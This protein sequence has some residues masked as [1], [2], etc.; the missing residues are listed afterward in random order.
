MNA[1][2]WATWAVKWLEDLHEWTMGTPVHTPGDLETPPPPTQ[3]PPV[4]LSKVLFQ[5]GKNEEVLPVKKEE[6]K[7]SVT[8]T[9]REKRHHGIGL[10]SGGR[11]GPVRTWRGRGEMWERAESI[12]FHSL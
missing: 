6:R 3:P 2:L 7:T 9:H 5:G 10:K 11:D 12:W 4:T 8:D 1:S